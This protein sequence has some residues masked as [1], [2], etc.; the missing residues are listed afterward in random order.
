MYLELK[1]LKIKYRDMNRLMIVVLVLIFTSCG[2]TQKIEQ[3]VKSTIYTKW[4]LTLLDGKAVRIEKPIYLELTD[5]NKVGGFMGCNR[6]GGDY[7]IEN[8]NQIRF[9]N[10]ITTRMACSELVLETQVLKMLNTVDNFTIDNEKLM[11]S[12]GSGKPLATFHRMRDDAIVNKYWKLK[13]LGDQEIKMA[14]NQERE[15]HFTLRSDNTISGFAGCNH[16]SGSYELKEENRIVFNENMAVTMMA[17]P[18]VE[19]NERAFLKVFKQAD[20]YS[21]DG[22]TLFLNEGERGSIATFEAVYFH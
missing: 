8:D 15:Q 12:I 4:E 1:T 16:F 6:L 3:T 13:K 11:L 2:T 22:D 17:C 18:D 9:S 20:N 19:V 7:T 21:I 5:D 10:L 14:K